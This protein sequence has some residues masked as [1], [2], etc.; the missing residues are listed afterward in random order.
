MSKSFLIVCGLFAT[1]LCGR[2]Q[3]PAPA[4]ADNAAPK[5]Y[6]RAAA[7]IAIPGGDLDTSLGGA[8][9]FGQNFGPH[10]L[11]GEVVLFKSSFKYG[12]GDIRFL[13][14]LVNY[15]YNVRLA[16]R[17]TGH[18]GVSV[19]ATFEHSNGYWDVSGTAFTYGA[20]AGLS[21]RLTSVMSLETSVRRLRLEKT[22]VGGGNITLV[23]LGLSNRF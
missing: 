12:Y 19:G 2:A 14:V 1:A 13:P 10:A 4:P 20:Q 16:E 9:A 22:D 21:F 11:E 23:Y 7:V 8:I 3:T 15:R 5:Y 17:L 18:L 6:A